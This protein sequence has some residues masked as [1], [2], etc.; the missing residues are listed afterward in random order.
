MRVATTCLLLLIA[1]AT[2]AEAATWRDITPDIGIADSVD[3]DPVRGDVVA[4]SG[5]VAVRP[6]GDGP[7]RGCAQLPSGTAV[8]SPSARL[9]DVVRTAAV[10]LPTSGALAVAL[11]SGALAL[12]DAGCGAWRIRRPRLDGEPVD[13]TALERSGDRLLASTRRGLV[14]SDD[15]GGTWQRAG[16]DLPYA[17]RM[18]LVAARGGDGVLALLGDPGRLA[19]SADAGATFT[20]TDLRP[21]GAAVEPDG[22]VWAEQALTCC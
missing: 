22:T 11:P 9:A 15:R 1:C 12:A 14:A 16:G 2:P 17:T 21:D 4:G 5:Q 10:Q 7:F 6:P 19:C 8:A 3:V 18:L 20:L 13:V